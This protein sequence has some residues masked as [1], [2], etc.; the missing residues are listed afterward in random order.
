MQQQPA[1]PMD[2]AHCYPSEQ[3]NLETTDAP[4]LRMSATHA[5]SF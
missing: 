5:G 3:H 1:A 4:N 2:E